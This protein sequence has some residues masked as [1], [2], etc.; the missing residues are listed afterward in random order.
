M[1]CGS[2]FELAGI[3][4]H[5][6]QT[7]TADAADICGEVLERLD[8]IEDRIDDLQRLADLQLE[9]TAHIKTHLGKRPS[10]EQSDE[11]AS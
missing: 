5:E 2:E 7:P 9:S 1:R 3:M 4:R 10:A 8:H 6:H 11:I